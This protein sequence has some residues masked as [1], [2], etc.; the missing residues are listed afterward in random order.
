MTTEATVPA[1]RVARDPVGVHVA[2]RYPWFDSLRAIAALS[3]LVYHAANYAAFSPEI[4][5]YT[6]RLA[7]GVSLFFVI[8]AFLL[9]RPFARAHMRATPGG[10]V[11]GYAW[12]RL[13]RI[14][15]AYWVAL[16]II[17][18]V[19]SKQDVFGDHGLLY[20]GFAQVYS[21][22]Y[23]LGGLG[24]AWSLAV[25]MSLYAFLPVWA[26]IV[27]RVPATTE[28]QRLR[29]QLAGLGLVALAG[30]L[31][32]VF[33][34]FRPD[35]DEHSF[36]LSLSILRY[37]DLFAAGM[38]IAVISV[39]YE[40][41]PLPAILR[42]LDR[43]PGITWVI[44]AVAFWIA[45]TKVGLKPG[46]NEQATPRITWE[47]FYL[48][49]II[50]VVIVL[51]F[52]FGEQRRGWLR[53]VLSQRWLL[54]FGAISYAVYLWHGFV[55][56]ELRDL[57]IARWVADVTHLNGFIVYVVLTVLF[58][59]AIA[60]LSFRF[61]ERPAMSLRGRNPFA[62][63]GEAGPSRLAALLLAACGAALVVAGLIGTGWLT[64]DV[65]LV[66]LGALLVLASLFR[67]RVSSAHV[68]VATLIAA[69]LLAGGLALSGIL[70]PRVAVGGG[71]PDLLPPTQVAAVVD[72][73]AVRLFVDGRQIAVARDGETISGTG[74]LLIG[75]DPA[76]QAS[77]IGSIDEVALFRRPLTA[78]EL[79]GL[80]ARGVDPKGDA[81]HALHAVRGLASW[82]RLGDLSGG[83]APNVI[84]DEPSGRVVGVVGV[85]GLLA[86][87]PDG[88]AMFDG[89]PGRI[90]VDGPV[91]LGPR[92]TVTAWAAGAP[93]R[94]NR[95]VISA[96]GRY[97]IKLDLLGRWN[98]AAHTT[99][100]TAVAIAP[101]QAAAGP[102]LPPGTPVQSR[103]PLWAALLAAGVA[104]VTLV[105]WRRRT[106]AL[107]GTR[108]EE[109]AA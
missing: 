24:V 56:A 13:L 98:A 9:Y 53:K 4:G 102:S 58:S 48:R 33:Y 5:Q 93:K 82:W 8:S 90:A 69:A 87:D 54:W 100:G 96:A 22:S 29:V 1:D 41:R 23:L 26:W 104:L 55:L 76:G 91:D 75:G 99:K 73:S 45:A 83:K 92:Y 21:P 27:S 14:V 108:P 52:V 88:A 79:A 43:F 66:S 109:V 16:T 25:E 28:A 106:R 37:L 38:A 11:G 20:Y 12:R 57:G 86:G 67:D 71:V 39:W 94:S 17:A 35:L 77:W 70:L 97:D 31:F 34:A 84:E 32:K 65:F 36:A 63:T 3:V 59:A 64:I 68:P 72:G 78:A 49:W 101:Q 42:P 7:V 18:I 105:L 51:P 50:A 60:A 2:G 61:V 103:R 10:S 6:S 85:P 15:P 95:T 30:V 80:R 89:G 40:D 74:P 19:L 47:I 107:L 44:A 81:A 46:Q 62:P